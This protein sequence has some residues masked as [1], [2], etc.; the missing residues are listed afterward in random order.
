M[1]PDGRKV[2]FHVVGDK[3]G[4]FD[5]LDIDE[6]MMDEYEER[7]LSEKEYASDDLFK[8]LNGKVLLLYANKIGTNIQIEKVLK[9][10]IG[11]KYLYTIIYVGS[12]GRYEIKI[13]GDDDF[14]FDVKSIE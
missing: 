11:D 1:S 2:D 5:I 12:N 3:N 14:E 4:T 7:M 9:Q 6:S 10:K 8:F 13:E